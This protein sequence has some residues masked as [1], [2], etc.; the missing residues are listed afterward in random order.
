MSPRQ[1]PAGAAVGEH[2]W[3]RRDRQPMRAWPPW[4]PRPR[5][6]A[7]PR[8][9]EQELPRPSRPRRT[10]SGGQRHGAPRTQRPR[11]RLTWP[12]RPSGAAR[13]VSSAPTLL[14]SAN[15][16]A[17]G[18]SRGPGAGDPALERRDLGCAR[19]AAG[20]LGTAASSAVGRSPGGEQQ[21]QRLVERQRVGGQGLS[22]RVE[23][24]RPRPGWSERR[25]QLQPVAAH[26]VDLAVVGDQRNGGRAA[27]PACVGRVTAGGRPRS[28]RA[29]RRRDP[30]TVC[31]RVS[32]D[33][34]LE[35]DRS[36]RS[37]RDAQARFA[38][39]QGCFPV[40]AERP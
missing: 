31:H 38:A 3:G 29:A 8:I 20:G 39:L 40:A 21:L 26:R 7:T 24:S 36:S 11:S 16:S 23:S 22:G 14:P 27:R 1:V 15:T 35:H 34:A 10:V 2:R 12:P 25:Q 5:G 17:A 32:R 33:Q 30:G 19:G 9:D 18:P 37:R 4:P 6:S 28:S 13:S